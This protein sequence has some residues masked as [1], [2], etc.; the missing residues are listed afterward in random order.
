MMN[1]TA[2]TCM[3]MSWLIPNIEHAIGIRSNEPPATPDA[4]QAA[5]V[6]MTHST[7]V[8]GSG[9]E[10]PRVWHV[11][12]VMTV[13]VMAAPSMLMVDPNGMLIEKKSLSMP[14]RSHNVMLTG[15]LAA[16]L[17]EKNAVI[18]LSLKQVNTNG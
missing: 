14:K 8:I 6:E 9:T 16:E 12:R 5:N 13:I 18:P 7:I 1:P 17:L 10:M 11:A 3:E 4:P 15:M 2:T